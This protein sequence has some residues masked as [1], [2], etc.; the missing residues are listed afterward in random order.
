MPRTTRRVNLVRLG[1]FVVLQVVSVLVNE[2]PNQGMDVIFRP[3]QPI[4]NSGVNVP[5]DP[6]VKLG[7]VKLTHLVSTGTLFTTV[8]RSNNLCLRVKVPTVQLAGVSQLHDALSNF[9]DGTVNF[10]KE[11]EHRLITRTTEP[12]RSEPLSGVSL[13]LWQT[14]EVTLGHL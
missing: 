8:D 4:L 11:E 5:D 9:R 6:A 14:N 13:N 12:I 3:S 10:V 2:V 7:R 1:V